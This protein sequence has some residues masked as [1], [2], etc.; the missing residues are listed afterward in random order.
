M[1]VALAGEGVQLK[2]EESRTCLQWMWRGIV[3]STIDYYARKRLRFKS[4]VTQ[5]YVNCIS[6][7]SDL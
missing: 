2:D 4:C 6:L 7:L 3:V 5:F 1:N